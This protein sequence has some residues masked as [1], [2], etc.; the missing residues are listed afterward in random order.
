[1]FVQA[2]LIGLFYWYLRCSIGYTFNVRW[3]A[4]P[5]AIAVPIGLIMGDVRQAVI[6]GA[7]IQA[8]YIG[9]V[10]GLGGVVTVD[11]ALA[12]CVAI[13]IALKSG[14]A[15]ELAVTMAIPFGL[16]GTLSSNIYKLIMSYFC[17]MADTCAEQGDTKKIRR[18]AFLYP[19]M[20]WFPL[21]VIPVTA[22]LWLGPDAVK[23]VLDKFPQEFINGLIAAG[24][25]LPALGFAMT[26]RVIGRK[27]FLPFFFL[28]FFL[29]QYFKI[30][31]MGAAIF[32]LLIAAIYIQMMGGDVNAKPN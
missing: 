30:T 12:T 20:V 13:P 15:P 21:T 5:V 7:Y 28:G 9:I 6:M 24:G 25:I 1:M 10:S 29:I 31:T 4:I 18:L 11:K 22:I 27:N 14:M 32:G 8:V 17:H 23:A 16:L 26:V 3:S 2:L 19:P